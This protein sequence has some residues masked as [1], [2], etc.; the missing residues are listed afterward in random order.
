MRRRGV[1]QGIWCGRMHAEELA[2]RC[3]SLGEAEEMRRGDDQGQ[4]CGRMHA[5]E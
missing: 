2:I 1:S 5:E 3:N 4:W